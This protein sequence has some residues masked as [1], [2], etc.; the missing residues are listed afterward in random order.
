MF[1][2]LTNVSAI[3]S[4]RFTRRKLQPTCTL[5]KLWRSLDTSQCYTCNE[6]NHSLY[7]FS[8]VTFV[9]LVEWVPQEKIWSSRLNINLLQTGPKVSSIQTALPFKVNV[10]YFYIPSFQ[11]VK[12]L[13]WNR[14][15]DHERFDQCNYVCMCSSKIFQSRMS[16]QALFKAS[17]PPHVCFEMKT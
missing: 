11:P 8:V 6:S 16:L 4:S 13:Q 14:T 7:S 1:C 9:K 5:N 15:S 2:Y 3:V 17:I 10:V 12:F